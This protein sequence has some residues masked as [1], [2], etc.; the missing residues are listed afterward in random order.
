MLILNTI[1]QLVIALL[2]FLIPVGV[3]TGVVLLVMSANQQ[4][5]LKKK[6]V[7]KWGIYSIVLPPIILFVILSVWGLVNILGGTTLKQ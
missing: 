1:I 3:I 7:K 5:P 6:K 4:D 2:M